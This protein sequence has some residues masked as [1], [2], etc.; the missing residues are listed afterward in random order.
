MSISF[1][2]SVSNNFLLTL[3]QTGPAT[4]NS[5]PLIVLS[6]EGSDFIH[7]TL[8]APFLG[9]IKVVGERIGQASAVKLSFAAL[10]KGSIALALNVGLLAEEWDVRNHLESAL[11]DCGSA[12]LKTLRNSVPQNVAKVNLF[13]LFDVLS[14][15]AN[16]K[17]YP[18]Q[19]HRW[20]G[21]AYNTLK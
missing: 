12:M 15:R 11:E 17:S 9:R 16:S 20:I 21:K 14:T 5:C 8:S 10:N 18:L 1:K 19:A 6:G 2:N 4:N 7:S 13:V 3:L